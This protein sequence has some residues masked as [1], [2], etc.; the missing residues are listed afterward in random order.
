MLTVTVD[1]RGFTFAIKIVMT[2]MMVVGVWYVW[3]WFEQLSAITTQTETSALAN[4][5]QEDPQARIA[6]IQELE[7]TSPVAA[8]TLQPLGNS[9]YVWIDTENMTISLFDGEHEVNVIPIVSVPPRESPDALVPG[10][11]TVDE[12]EEVLVSTVTKVRFPSYV[13]FGD[14]FALHGIPTQAQGEELE[15]TFAGTSV[16]LATQD[17][18]LVAD[19]VEQGTMVYVEGS[20][21][22]EQGDREGELTVGEEEMPATSAAAYALTDLYSGQTFIVKNGDARYPIASITKLVTA[23]VAGEVVGHGEEVRAPNGERY[24]LGDLFYPLLL[25]SDNG[26]AER[27]AMHVGKNV[28]LAHMNAYVHAHGMGASSFSDSSGLSPANL[29]SA[30]DLVTLAQH[31][32]KDKEYILAMTSE[33]DMTITSVNGSAWNVANQNKLAKD[34]HFR[35]GKLG[36][37]DEAGQTSLAVFNVPLAGETRPVA[38]IILNSKDW[39]QDTR[40]LLQWLVDNVGR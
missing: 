35:G 10:A 25:R 17:A 32:S 18:A 2:M 15:E 24:L 1:T 9:T 31:L 38:V 20:D 11:Y 26:V 4:V 36:Y 5:S 37:T 12:I 16:E 33:A 27:I 19:F 21:V 8:A 30:N 29:S 3:M 40:T 39:K 22:Q 28:F 23:A 6:A 7:G 13:T 14:R 34:P